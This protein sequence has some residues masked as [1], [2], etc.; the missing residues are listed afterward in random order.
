MN[1][2]QSLEFAD[3]LVFAKT[4]KSLTP[5]QKE[6]IKVSW[7]NEKYETIKSYSLGHI[8]DTAYEL[9]EQ[10]EALL[11]GQ[12]VVETVNKN[13][14][15][16]VFL[17]LSPDLLFVDKNESEQP[18]VERETGTSP[19]L[20]VAEPEFPEG[21][22]DLTS[23]FY[24]ERPLV[25]SDCYKTVLKP[26]SLIRIKAPRQMGKT[27]LM[28]R[29][30]DRARQQGYR[31][32]SLNF[33]ILDERDF[34][35]LKTFLQRF[36]ASVC[37]RLEL[38]NR[39]NDYWDDIVYG[40][41][42]NCT[43]YFEEYLLSKTSSP[44]VLGLDEVDCIFQYPNIA[45]DFF[46]LLRAWH[47]EAK[48][49]D[50]WKKLRLV[51]VHSTEVYIPLDTNQSPFNVGLPIELPE[52]NLEQ[53]LDLAKRYELDLKS[54]QVEQLRALIGGHPYLIGVA[55]Y[56]LRS[57]KVMFETLLQTA[58]TEEGLYSDHLR[59]HLWNLERHPKLAAAFI[60]VVA[61]SNPVQLPSEQAFKLESMGLVL[62]QG[63]GV[64]PRCNLYRQYFCTRL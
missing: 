59:R 28:A 44:L 35:D 27:S 32:V 24:V 61:A 51:V 62:L 64:E 25:E 22:V 58:A 10:L 33:Q 3:R 20:P 5:L 40:S 8:K 31:T 46:G 17:N 14:F 39:I 26:G 41:K 1:L 7:N 47:E 9:W 11:K 12:D 21:Q 60:Q 18:K 54:N 4:E 36:C 52:F 2:E 48:S 56:N 38:P 19:P 49:R 30:L 37:R 16:I 57:K 15:R 43:V 55:L 50:I 63:D 45:T 29:I 6:I 42:D 13:T 34:I 23:K 53:V